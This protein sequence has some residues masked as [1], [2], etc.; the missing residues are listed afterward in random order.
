MTTY[1]PLQEFQKRYPSAAMLAA[2]MRLGADKFEA[3]YVENPRKDKVV[4]RDLFTAW[5]EKCNLSTSNDAYINYGAARSM[6]L[7]AGPN[8]WC[9]SFYYHML[10]EESFNHFH[11]KN[12]SHNLHR[13][14][15]DGEI[16]MIRTYH[17]LSRADHIKYT[18]ILLSL[19][20]RVESYV[21]LLL[22]L[23]GMLN[24]IQ[25]SHN[26][27][28][29]LRGYVKRTLIPNTSTKNLRRTVDRWLQVREDFR[30]RLIG[31]AL[32]GD[33]DSW[34][35]PVGCGNGGF[36]FTPIT[37]NIGLKAEGQR[38]HHCVGS[39]RTRCLYEVG[40]SHIYS[41]TAAGHDDT[42]LQVIEEGDSFRR[43]SLYHA[44]DADV[45]DRYII[46]AVD[47]FI[48]NLNNNDCGYDA[49]A[50]RDLRLHYFA[51]IDDRMAIIGA[52]DHFDGYIFLIDHFPW[53]EDCVA[54]YDDPHYNYY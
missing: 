19:G 8:M 30:S 38:M 15:F 43:G 47:T 28:A 1:N 7:S 18:E 32:M 39:Y 22:G 42:T 35:T 45:T 11:N 16:D 6:Y 36:T 25:W 33:D 5:L 23:D 31:Y 34:I 24:S 4:F 44:N 41:V 2:E 54:D 3:H 10:T 52:D 37:N 17:D 29:A 26:H 20:A 27:F 50:A 21:D 46:D 51:R 40:N 14:P 49:K 12:K 13:L 48:N 53:L 9:D